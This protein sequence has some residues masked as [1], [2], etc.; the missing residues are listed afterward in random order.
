MEGKGGVLFKGRSPCLK[1]SHVKKQKQIEDESLLSV[2]LLFR[3]T[4][5]MA[6]V[7]LLSGFPVDTW[8]G[9]EV[10]SFSLS[11]KWHLNSAGMKPS[12]AGGPVWMLNE[13]VINLAGRSDA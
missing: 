7:S 13:S 10:C 5:G 9:S 4:R 11:L 2:F 12:G 6:V 3:F 1:P 8:K